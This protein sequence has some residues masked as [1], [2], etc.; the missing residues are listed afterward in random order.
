MHKKITFS[1]CIIVKNYFLVKHE[2]I[3]NWW[4]LPHHEAWKVWGVVWSCEWS[5]LRVNSMANVVK[6][7]QRW[8]RKRATAVIV[9]WT[10]LLASW[11]LAR[12]GWADLLWIQPIPAISNG[13]TTG[14]LLILPAKSVPFC[15]FL[16]KYTLSFHIS[17]Y[18]IMFPCVYVQMQMQNLR[19]LLHPCLS[20]WLT[21]L[22]TAQDQSQVSSLLNTLNELN[23]NL[24]NR[25]SF[26]IIEEELKERI[27]KEVKGP[28]REEN[29][30]VSLLL[31]LWGTAVTW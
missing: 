3:W 15:C 19:P 16:M 27:G 21:C 2:R 1:Q 23:Q 9:I 14:E 30:E 29:Q 22:H 10:L 12:R 13:S 28:S 20:Q 17:I 11:A 26:K 24:R 25:G 8:P 18:K 4:K 6:Y 7:V 5:S 31:L